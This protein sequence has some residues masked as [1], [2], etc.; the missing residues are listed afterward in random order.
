MQFRLGCLACGFAWY[1]VAPCRLNQG[2]LPIHFL[3]ARQGKYYL[4]ST[5]A[6]GVVTAASQSSLAT[7]CSRKVNML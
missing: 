5:H 3:Y 4:G 6:R 2:K 7:T 1:V